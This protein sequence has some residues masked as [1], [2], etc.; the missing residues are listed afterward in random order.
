MYNSCVR[1][2]MLYS[3]ECWPLRQEDKKCLERSE[4]AMLLWMCNIKKTA[5]QHKFPPKSSET[6]KPGFSV[7]V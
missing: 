4:R 3:S 2:T 7:K 6:E 1:G 5:C